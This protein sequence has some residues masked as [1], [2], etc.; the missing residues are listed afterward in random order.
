MLNF[1]FLWLSYISHCNIATLVFAAPQMNAMN[2]DTFAAAFGIPTQKTLIPM[3][4]LELSGGVTQSVEFQLFLLFS[5]TSSC[6]IAAIVGHYF[7][8]LRQ[9]VGT[10][11]PQ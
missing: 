3:I 7:F 5:Y 9:L 4:I 1:S 11:V 2:A 6:H 10:T 8:P